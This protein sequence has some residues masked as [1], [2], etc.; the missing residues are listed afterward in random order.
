MAILIEKI[1][2][3]VKGGF[4]FVADLSRVYHQTSLSSFQLLKL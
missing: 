2:G 4:E 3:V 1:M